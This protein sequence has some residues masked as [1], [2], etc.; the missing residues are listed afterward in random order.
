MYR[1]IAEG[2][3]TISAAATPETLV[4]ATQP[5]AR[6]WLGAPYNVATGVATNTLPVNAGIT[7]A[8]GGKRP[9]FPTNFEGVYIDID[10]AFKLYVDVGVNGETINYQIFAR[11]R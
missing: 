3:K 9:V 5:C 7:A 8:S 10:D 11:V 2:T 4:A 6:V 1:L